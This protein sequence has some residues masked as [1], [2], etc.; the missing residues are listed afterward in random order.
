MY[1]TGDKVLYGIHGVCT[2]TDREHRIMDRKETVYLVLEPLTQLG[3]RYLVPAHNEAAIRK[4]QP[5][6]NGEAYEKLLSSGEIRTDCWINGDSLRKQ[7]YRELLSSADRK[8]LLQML[9]SLYRYRAAQQEAGK[10]LHMCDE[11]FLQDAEKLL[12][13][14]LSVILDMTIQEARVYLRKK[15]NED[16]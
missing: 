14:E 11:S 6:L 4:L 1:Q 8:L 2:V 15:L 3:A 7:R 12:G 16:A 13:S 9:C 10:K 5:L